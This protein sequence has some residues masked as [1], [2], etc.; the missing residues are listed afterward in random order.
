MKWHPAGQVLWLFWRDFAPAGYTLRISIFERCEKT[1]TTDRPVLFVSAWVWGSSRGPHTHAV[2]APWGSQD[3]RKSKEVLKILGYIHQEDSCQGTAQ[4]IDD[5]ICVFVV[6]W[7]MNYD[8]L[9]V[10]HHHHA[11]H[12]ICPCIPRAHVPKTKQVQTG[13]AQRTA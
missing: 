7:S 8:I 12:P 11:K 13:G 6:V 2:N 4:V 3:V 1:I 9:W 10:C 5:T